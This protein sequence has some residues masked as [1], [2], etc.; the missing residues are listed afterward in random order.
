[1]SEKG[2]SLPDTK[3]LNGLSLEYSSS[4][5]CMSLAIFFFKKRKLKDVLEKKWNITLSNK[6]K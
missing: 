2:Y 3:F 6:K 4:M 1:M 5:N